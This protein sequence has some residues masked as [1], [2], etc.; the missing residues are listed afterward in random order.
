MSWYFAVLK[1]FATFSGRARRKEFWYFTLF[2]FIVM[3]LLSFL[4]GILASMGIFPILSVVYGVAVILPSIGVSI[5]RLHDTGR[6][7]W[8]VFISVIPLIGAIIYIVFMAQDSKPE[9]NQYGVNPK[10]DFE[11]V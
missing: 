11:V 10:G 9:A 5:R 1:K 2:N 6:S 8:W 7:G 4:D 3:I